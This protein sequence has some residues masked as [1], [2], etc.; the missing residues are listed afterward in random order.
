MV[1]PNLPSGMGTVM[2]GDSDAKCVTQTIIYFF[3]LFSPR[4]PSFGAIA[5]TAASLLQVSPFTVIIQHRLSLH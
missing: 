2:C 3:L 5:D 1:L 4:R